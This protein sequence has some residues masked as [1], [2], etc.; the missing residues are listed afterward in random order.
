[1]IYLKLYDITTGTTFTKYFDC[2]FDKQKF[3]RKLKFSKKI[4]IRGENI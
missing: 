3:K 1:M 2:E 4:F